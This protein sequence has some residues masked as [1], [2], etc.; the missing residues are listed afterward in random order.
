MTGHLDGSMTQWHDLP[1]RLGLA[2][3]V[4]GMEAA[5]GAGGRGTSTSMHWHAHPVRCMNFA[6]DG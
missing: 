2:L 1:L 3:G 6:S 5:V 4:S